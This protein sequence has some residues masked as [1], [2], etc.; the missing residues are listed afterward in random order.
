NEEEAEATIK[1]MGCED[2]ESWSDTLINTESDTQGCKTIAF[3]FMGP[4]IT[5][6]IYLCGTLGRTKIDLHQ[7]SHALNLKLA[8]FDGGASAPVCSPLVTKACVCVPAL[9]PYLLALY[10]VMKE[11]GTHVRCIEQMQRLFTTKLY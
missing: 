1:V 5:H 11:K 7:T 9:G 2:W 3:C 10:R 8:N 4:E 6:P